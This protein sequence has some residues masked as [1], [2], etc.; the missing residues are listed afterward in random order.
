M[1]VV[2]P[3]IKAEMAKEVAM[4]G[5]CLSLGNTFYFSSCDVPV[6]VHGQR[7]IP[8]AFNAP[9][10]SLLS[11]S[12]T[13]TLLLELDNANGNFD[14]FV[15]ADTLQGQRSQLIAIYLNDAG[16]VI[17]SYN[18]FSGY[19]DAFTLSATTLKIELVDEFI[20]W[21]KKPLRQC[22]SSCSWV[23]KGVECGYTNNE[24]LCDKTYARCKTL[25]QAMF[26]G[27]FRFLPAIEEADIWWGQV[28]K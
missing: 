26:F 19:I 11:S 1:R 5:H 2:D 21:N 20:F 3:N 4:E 15:L 23:F 10:L 24:T 9:Q 28:H 18:V 12:A 13:G 14:R 7:Y 25:G 6:V 8:I 17:Y 27:G 16:A 22:T